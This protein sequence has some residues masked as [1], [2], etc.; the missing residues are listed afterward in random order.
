[1]TKTHVASSTQKAPDLTSLVVMVHCKPPDVP[2]V[3]DLGLGLQTD[4]AQ[5]TLGI[6]PLGIFLRGDAVVK[7]KVPRPLLSP[8]LGI[9]PIRL[10]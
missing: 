10:R 4:R 7:E 6:D 2:T 1:M 5:A 9:A 3:P 8:A